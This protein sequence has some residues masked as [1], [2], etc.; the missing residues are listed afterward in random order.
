MAD[1]QDCQPAA[2]SASVV[3]RVPAV[4]V[5]R[6]WGR[7]LAFR[8]QAS[9]LALAL[10]AAS[11]ATGQPVR[12]EQRNAAS[13]QT[14]APFVRT[15][16]AIFRGQELH[17][18][19][20]D[21]LAVHG[22]DMVLGP[23]EEVVA[24]HRRRPSMKVLTDSW[25]DRRDLAAA[26]DTLLWPDGTIP[27]VIEA[28]FTDKALNDIE[29]AIQEWNTK[30]V[31]T[32]VQRTTEPDYVRF[33][34][35]GFRPSEPYC[36]ANLGR[37][38]GEQSI[39]LSG[40]EGCGLDTTIHEIGHAVG[41]GHE[42]Q[43]HDRDEYITISDAQSYGDIRFAYLADTPGSRPY[44]YS[45]VMNYVQVGTIPPGIPL[46]S[47][48]LS[49]GDIDGVARLYGTDPTATT[50]STNP[51]GLAILVD[52][53]RVTT[54]AQFDWSPGSTHSLQV[55]TPQTVGGERFVFGRWS[56]GGRSRRTVA[57]SPGSTWF[58]ANYIAQRRI[59]S[60]VAPSEAGSVT[61]SPASRDGFYVQRQPV[62]VEAIADGSNNFLQ[63][64][65][66]PGLRRGADRRSRRSVPGASSSPASGATPYWSYWSSRGTGITEFC[67]IYTEEPTFLVD[68]NVAGISIDLGGQPRKIPWAF[69]AAEYPGGIWAKAPAT[70]PEEA[71]FDDIRYRFKRWSDGGRRA[72]RINVP[73]SGGNVGLEFT[74]EYRL[75]I[76]SRNHPDDADIDISPPS[77]DGFYAE[78]TQVQ[79]AAMP[80]SGWHF[81]GWIGEVSDY[82][83]VR[84][85][86]MDAA[87]TLEAV[88]AESEPIRPG[89]TKNVTLRASERF[90]LYSGSEGYNVLVPPDAA[91]VTVRFQSSS[92]AEVDLYVHRGGSVRWEPGDSGEAPLVHA[93][94]ESTSPGAT[95]TISINRESVPRL[96]SEVY[97]IGL[98][99]PPTLARIEGT[100]SVDV[101]RS[102]I[103]KV[104]PPALTFVSAADPQT[105][106]LT[107][108]TTGPVRYR[109]VSNA[110]WLTANPQE[111][112]RSGS[113]VEEISVIPHTTGAVLLNATHRG[114]LTV[115]KASGGPGE[116]TWTETGVEIPVVSTVVSRYSS[117][118]ISR[119][120]NA[121]TIDSRPQSGDTYGA[122]EE[123]RVS[124]SF[125][126]PVDVSGTPKLELS[127][128][129]RTRRVPWIG[130]GSTSICESGYK[131]LEFSY[132]VQAE[133]RDA[134]GI[135]IAAD[136]LAVDGGGMETAGGVESPLALA[137]PV[138][139]SAPDHKIDGSMATVPK[140]RRAGISSSPSNG[141]AY[142]AGEPIVAWV[143]FTTRVEAAG[144][145]R[146]ALTVGSQRRQASLSVLS[147]DGTVVF[148]RYQV[149]PYD[150]DSDGI[151][152][153][154]NALT[155]NGGSIRSP[156]GTDADLGLAAH[157]I[158]HSEDH[159]VDGGLARAPVVSG[160]GVFSSPSNGTA[161]RA[162]EFI[163]IWVRFTSRIEATGK[164]RLALTVGSQTRHAFYWVPNRDGTGLF[165]RYQVQSGDLDTH[166]I[167]IA[168][169]ALTL[170]G[171]SIR[172][173]GGTDADL[174]L[175]AHATLNFAGHKVD[176]SIAIVPQVSGVGFSGHPSNGTAYRAGEFVTVW[177]RFTSQIEA[178]GRPRLALTV[179]SQTRHASYWAPSRDRTALYFRY[180]V[181]SGDVDTDGIGI[182]AN[183]L[184]LNRGSIR[185]RGGTDAVLDLGPHAITDA[186]DHKVAGG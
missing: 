156:V 153:A 147:R 90:H 73:A 47:G 4:P 21:G 133:D 57:A 138:T 9:L 116:T 180:L 46:R 75:R 82:E 143:Q 96:S 135:R 42:H 68:S 8:L 44:D 74:R 109:I 64:N 136:A 130:N 174:G 132:L 178:T 76:A 163:T 70:V 36:R 121:V 20:V 18:E 79:V 108:E 80:G 167:G 171:G 72:H 131:S 98:A 129:D 148:F 128:G 162:E 152:I 105:V 12:P 170:N 11:M 67:A 181:Q 37:K 50:I 107:H 88:F 38:G 89:E 49:P 159:K 183:A 102:G 94:F 32:L 55:I 71:D 13:G 150:L 115:L 127:V 56:D 134:D 141:T 158:A 86:V 166:G 101:R 45:S 154:A 30:T 99:V 31:I 15:G 54:P 10:G 28:G 155:L 22:G 40:P 77:E 25:P 151:G 168:A 104:W 93:D 69:R 83:P 117:R 53:E 175:G 41:L 165:F 35:R 91:E 146:L 125:P 48:G 52:G 122:G 173:E 145:P 24:E 111:W 92:A 169:N 160:V 124:V 112:V 16:V 39:W 2:A 186:A 27:F 3:L 140:V 34:P 103:V 5:G 26:E 62:A 119:R 172:S 164:P 118:H 33:E 59:L 1:R 161:Y 176:G 95:E 87:K 61:V 66:V 113:G 81:A 149:Q 179:G 65:P 126:E 17:Y 19:I 123:I 23:V 182:A 6:V 177:V 85:I 7:L 97:F 106:R 43:R 139:V 63:W 157:A 137:G 114:S 142:G 144:N 29:L 120:A 185:S 58:E 14:T 84:T 51:A 78:G 100:L 110:S 60:C 184:T